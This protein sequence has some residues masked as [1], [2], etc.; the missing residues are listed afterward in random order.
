[1]ASVHPCKHSSVMKK[2]IERIDKRF[3]KDR[4]GRGGGKGET[5]EEEEEEEQ[6]GLRVDQYLVVFLKFMSSIGRLPSPLPH[7]SFSLTLLPFRILLLHIPATKHQ[8]SRIK[9]NQIKKIST[10]DR[11]GRHCSF[12]NLLGKKKPFSFPNS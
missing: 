2:F 7:P 3:Q 12:L 8:R 1:M 9:T 5:G 11:S 10:H 6:R 4:I